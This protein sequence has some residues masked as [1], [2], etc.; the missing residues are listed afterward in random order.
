MNIPARLSSLEHLA[1]RANLHRTCRT[2][3][4]PSPLAGC[5][6][7]VRG[8]E[9]DRCPSCGEFV[10]EDGKT[11]G[12]LAPGGKVVRH[13]IILAPESERQSPVADLPTEIP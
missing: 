2:C 9:P 13:F 11:V 8:D 3:G 12:M 7:V 6:I 10:D 1:K 5:V 4:F